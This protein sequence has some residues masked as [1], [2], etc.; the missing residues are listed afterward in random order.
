MYVQGASARKVKVLME[1]RIGHSF[2][3]SPI[4][5]IAKKLDGELFRFAR[6]RSASRF[7]IWFSTHVTKRFAWIT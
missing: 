4:S 2:P 1:E 3:A 6:R 5:T 7:P